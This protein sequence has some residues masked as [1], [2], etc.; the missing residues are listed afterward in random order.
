MKQLLKLIAF[1]KHH[2]QY[3]PAIF[4]YKLRLYVQH[5]PPQLVN[6]YIV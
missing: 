6:L 3:V 5:A 2:A 4:H 1:L